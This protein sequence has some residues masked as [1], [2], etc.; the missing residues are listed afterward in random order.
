M[1]SILVN[2]LSRL[3][4]GENRKN[5]DL[6]KAFVKALIIGFCTT[7]SIRSGHAINKDLM[8]FM[9]G[10][11]CVFSWMILLFNSYFFAELFGIRV[12]G[13]DDGGNRHSSF[14]KLVEDACSEIQQKK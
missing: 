7:K 1:A 8:I 11:N 10:K 9:K 14:P 3:N 5:P 13:I 4:T 6:D 12:A 2:G